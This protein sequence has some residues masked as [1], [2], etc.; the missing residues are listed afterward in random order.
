MIMIRSDHNAIMMKSDSY[1]SEGVVV[2]DVVNGDDDGN[3]Y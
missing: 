1:L 2:D 3:E